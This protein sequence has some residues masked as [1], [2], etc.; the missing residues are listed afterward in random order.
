MRR[1]FQEGD[2][3]IDQARP[4]RRYHHAP[5]PAVLTHLM[6]TE[7]LPEPLH[8]WLVALRE[9]LRWV[10]NYNPPPGPATSGHVDVTVTSQ[11]DQD[12]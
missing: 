9:T 10:L 7:R 5:R 8:W 4:L 12:G 11:E 1:Q 6:P 2:A 3:C